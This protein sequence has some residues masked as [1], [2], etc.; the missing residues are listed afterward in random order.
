MIV[1]DRYGNEIFKT[2]DI[3]RGWDG[4]YKG[5]SVPAGAYSYIIKGSDAKGKIFLKGSVVVI[6]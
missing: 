3:A 5:V 2:T 1:Y 6:R 4:T